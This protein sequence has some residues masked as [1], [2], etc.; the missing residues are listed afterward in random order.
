MKYKKIVLKYLIFKRI[1]SASTEKRQ[2]IYKGIEVRFESEFSTA[3]LDD[4]ELLKLFQCFLI[5]GSL[6]ITLFK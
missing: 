6:I 1:L 2:N 3:T 5:K 4:W